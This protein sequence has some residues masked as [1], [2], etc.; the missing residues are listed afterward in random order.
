M[1]LCK[2]LP[3]TARHPTINARPVVDELTTIEFRND[4]WGDRWVCLDHIALM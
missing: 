1:L 3:P 4:G 2:E